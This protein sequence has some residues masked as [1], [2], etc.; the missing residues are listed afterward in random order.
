MRRTTRITA[1][2]AAALMTAAGAAVTTAS[3]TPQA[4]WTVSNPSANDTFT[5]VNTSGVSA[6]LT[7][8]TTGATITCA[9]YGANGTAV[10]GTYASGAGLATI[11][12]A[13]FGTTA[14]KCNGPL[15]SK[16][17]SSS[18]QPMKLNGV[19]YAGG[20]TKGTLTSIKVN[21]TGTS[22]LGTCTATIEGSANTG[23][24]SNTGVLEIVP[25]ATPALTVTAASGACA[26]LINTGNKA[27]FG[28]KYQ[29]TPA[30]T[31]TSP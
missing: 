7:N 13:T 9:V 20:V 10:D 4:T 3:A 29:V 6:V 17:V 25:D 27:K 11:A 16:W 18:A 26:G 28:A 24:Y 15:G 2:T 21:L 8:V 5:A 14:N 31:V 22:L 30:I 12:S 1:I 19:S 23:S